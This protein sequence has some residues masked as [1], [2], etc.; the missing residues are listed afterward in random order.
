MLRLK[1]CEKKSPLAF[2][3]GLNK[4]KPIP[5]TGGGAIVVQGATG[6]HNKEKPGFWARGG[7]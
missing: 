2:L 3:R 6:E 4:E 1:V 7:A 5:E